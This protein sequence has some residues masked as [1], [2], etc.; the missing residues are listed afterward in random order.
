MTLTQW[1]ACVRGVP[2]KSLAPLLVGVLAAPAAHAL[3]TAQWQA[4]APTLQAALECRTK[5]DTTGAA[6]MSLP[7][8]AEGG[9][10]AIKPPVPFLVFGL[11][12]RE[13]A[14]FIDA[15]GELG[16][17]YTADLGAS[18]AAVR[19]AAKLNAEDGRTTPMGDLTLGG[20]T[21]PKLTCTVAGAYD[22]SDYQEN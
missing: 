13:V 16:E 1:M 20:D 12:V 11:P 18:L 5:P 4:V 8:D 17:S 2:M 9:I 21:S 14:I 15:S 7:H 22:E 6:W 10:A 3:D 19:K